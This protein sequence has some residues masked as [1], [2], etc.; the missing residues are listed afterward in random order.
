MLAHNLHDVIVLV[1]QRTCQSGKIC[2]RQWKVDTLLC[3][4]MG[5]NSCIETFAHIVA[6]RPT[7]AVPATSFCC[8]PALARVAAKSAACELHFHHQEHGESNEKLIER[9][10]RYNRTAEIHRVRASPLYF[11]TSIPAND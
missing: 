5:C 1:D 10:R 6:G 3:S 9:I 8:Q 4:T 11:K 2:D 7:I